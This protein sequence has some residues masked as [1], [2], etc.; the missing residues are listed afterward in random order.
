MQSSSAN[1]NS[2]VGPSGNFAPTRWSV[3]LA[4]GRSQSTEA[5]NALEELCRT[6]W[7]PLYAFIRRNGHSSEDAEDLAQE[8]FA[9]FL[10]KKFLESVDPAKGRFRSFLLAS[11]KHFLANQWDKSRAQKRGG[12]RQA[13]SL[14]RASAE[15]SYT[16]EAVENLSPDKVY[17]RRWALTLLERVLRRL[18]EEYVAEGKS[19]QFEAL[20][21]ALTGDRGSL[22]YAELAASLETSEGAIKVAVYR[23]RQRYRQ[24][25]RDEI[26]QTVATPEEIEDEIRALFAALE[27]G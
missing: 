21:S 16:I 20:K 6:Y 5:R 10:E 26:A 1:S 17:E 19:R 12:G 9:L 27:A 4:A 11:L 25:L 14:D 3:V 22:P 23:L 24:I 18:R 13:L 2:A 15:T 8:F 7:P